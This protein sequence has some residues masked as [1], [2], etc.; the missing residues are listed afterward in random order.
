MP[1]LIRQP[2]RLLS[3]GGQEEKSREVKL[4]SWDARMRNEVMARK[5]CS[6][7][8]MAEMPSLFI[9]ACI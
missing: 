8:V 9:L 6:R 7:E 4:R 5:S 2:R 1:G 3:V